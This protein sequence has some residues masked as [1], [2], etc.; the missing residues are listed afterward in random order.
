MAQQVKALVTKHDDLTSC[1]GHTW[2]EETQTYSCPL[3]V[4][5]VPCLHTD[6]T[7]RKKKN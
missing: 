5:G 1:P 6:T 4:V 7:K 2:W 3:T